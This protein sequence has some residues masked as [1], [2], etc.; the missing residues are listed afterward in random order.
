M[1]RLRC[2]VMAIRACAMGTRLASR[3][4]Q[5]QALAVRVPRVGG[6]GGKVMQVRVSKK[7]WVSAL[8]G[9]EVGTGGR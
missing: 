1:R 2:G 7:E 4:D 3:H 8:M 6:D 9:C 5:W